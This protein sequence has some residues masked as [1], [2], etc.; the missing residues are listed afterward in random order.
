LNHDTPHIR[1]GW[2]GSLRQPDLRNGV[3]DTADNLW[4]PV[5]VP[6]PSPSS[7]SDLYGMS[8]KDRDSLPEGDCLILPYVDY[9]TLYIQH[10]PLANV[11]FSHSLIPY[12]G[13]HGRKN[14]ELPACSKSCR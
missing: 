5:D 14:K 11:C 2:V 10:S 4:Q 8:S 12:S 9:G 6:F 13:L 3:Y 7:L 1:A